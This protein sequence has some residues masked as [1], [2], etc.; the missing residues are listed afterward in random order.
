M[1]MYVVATKRQVQEG[2]KFFQQCGFPHDSMAI[3]V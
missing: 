1:K 3:S 2:Y